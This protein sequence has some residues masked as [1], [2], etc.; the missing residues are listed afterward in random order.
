MSLSPST[1]VIVGIGQFNERIG[2]SSYRALSA[3][4]IAAESATRAIGDA[5]SLDRL[6]DHIDAIATTRTFDDSNPLRAQPFGR[7]NNFP[8][9][10]A[11]RLGIAPRIAVWE[12]GGGDSPQKLVSEFCLRL[13]TGECRMA[14]I[15]GAENISTAR[16]LKAEG[17]TADWSEEVDGSVDNRGMGLHGLVYRYNTN[18]G[19]V[20]TPPAY[21]LCETARRAALKQTPAEYSMEM[22]R[23]F[24]PF[25]SVAAANPYASSA[26]S[27]STAEE[28]VTVGE[29][30]RM[31]ASPYPQRLVARD[32][33]NQGAALLLTTVGVARELGIDERKWVFLVGHAA[34][35]EREVMERQDPGQYPA[36]VLACRDAMQQ[37]GVTTDDL[38]FFDFYSCYPIA[39]SSVA[40]DGLGLK[41]D[42][43]RGLTVT[44]GLPYF[45]GPGNNYSMHAIATMVERLRER[46]DTYG[47][48]GANG[49]YLSKYAVG[50]YSTRPA[51]FVPSDSAH[52]QA[53]IDSWPA[54]P[55]VTRPEGPATI[56]TFTVV[57]AKGVPDYA[58]VMCR[59][60]DGARFLAKTEAGDTSTI[61]A[62]L[63]SDPLGRTVHVRATDHGN[64]F[65]FAE[66]RLNELFPRRAVA[67]RATY[68]FAKVERRDH[69]LIV[70]IDRQEVRNALHP[71]ANEELAGIWDAFEADPD[72]WVAILTGAG[73]DAFSA[74]NDLKYTASGKPMWIPH[75]GFGGLTARI[76]TKPVI[77]AVNGHAMGGG[78]EM[79]LA[80]DI[81]VADERASFAL[82]EVKVG[83]VA[84][85]GGIVRLPREIPR[86]IA[87]EH[88]LTGRAIHARRAA[89]LGL[90]NR[91]TSAGEALAGALDI[92]QEILSVSPTSVRVSMKI[93]NDMDAGDCT[94]PSPHL[95]ELYTSEDY[96]EGPQAFK[97]KRKPVWKNR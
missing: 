53:T 44:G 16:W 96:R 66:S 71:P 32:Q 82:S 75:S 52:L 7:S 72:L 25:T 1:P 35:V 78:T 94:T 54:P 39:V 2:S 48:V 69:L 83:V 30:N 92:A 18:H 86:K 17:K 97:E 20:G 63:S 87:L 3:V 70:S 46:R 33:V 6:R 74:G 11:R 88:I 13:A 43:P 64:R 65:A 10:V 73:S 68:E 26:V 42:D 5:L 47:L 80:C 91:V 23:L 67:L 27:P 56:E 36:A 31:I 4:D 38:A 24:A 57:Y 19:L 61:D 12:K 60:A 77:A 90:V 79:A 59:N 50:I 49:G 95:D 37:A 93:V 21:G 58:V 34:T 14:L 8:R 62:M 28:L 84:A 55:R 41:A 76:R 81:V 85:C 45:G 29:R 9:S 15:A 40:I 51:P 22:G 89:E